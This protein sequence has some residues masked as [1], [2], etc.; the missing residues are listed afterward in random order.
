MA[1][2]ANVNLV[3]NPSPMTW[4]WMLN[5]KQGPTTNKQVRQALN[6]AWNRDALVKDLLLD[7]ATPAIAP[8][9]LSVRDTAMASNPLNVW[10][11]RVAPRFGGQ[12]GVVQP[13]AA[14]RQRV[15]AEPASALAR[16]E[17]HRRVT[18]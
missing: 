1:T 16:T 7:L 5:C 4:V 8:A 11:E 3:F 10:S 2:R 15:P 9:I 18:A 13:G 12:V 14:S 6:Y 17:C